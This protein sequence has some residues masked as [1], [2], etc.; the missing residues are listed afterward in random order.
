MCTV[1]GIVYSQTYINQNTNLSTTL[2]TST[3]GGVYRLSGYIGRVTSPGNPISTCTFTW[4][5]SGLSASTSLNVGGTLN[6]PG[7]ASF[8]EVINMAASSTLS[9]AV[10]FTGSTPYEEYN[11]YLVL[12]QLL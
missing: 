6:S 1:A 12:E 10:V 8:N 11:I 2:Y 5:D 3:S 4:T 7:W 9:I